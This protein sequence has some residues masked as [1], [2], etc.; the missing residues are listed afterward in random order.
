ML[1][2]GN[3]VSK[4]P[5]GNGTASQIY[6]DRGDQVLLRKSAINLYRKSRV[7]ADSQR[8]ASTAW[9]SNVFDALAEVTNGRATSS[10]TKKSTA[11][12]IGP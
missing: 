7:P 12:S 5:L 2:F 11:S 8:R 3:R 9:P 4:L 1:Q 6:Y 10:G